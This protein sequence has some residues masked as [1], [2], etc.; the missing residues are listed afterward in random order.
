MKTPPSKLP[1]GEARV[2]EAKAPLRTPSAAASSASA[3]PRYVAWHP[4]PLPQDLALASGLDQS[5]LLAL[6]TQGLPTP[7]S[8]AGSRE[9]LLADPRL[10][11]EEVKGLNLLAWIGGIGLGLAGMAAAAFSL[12]LVPALGPAVLLAGLAMGLAGPALGGWLVARTHKSRSAQTRALRIAAQSKALTPLQERV[13]ALAIQLRGVDLPEIA[14]RDLLSALVDLSA[15][16]SERPDQARIGELE[17]AVLAVEGLL[18]PS[19][20]AGQKSDPQAVL[21]LAQAAHQARGETR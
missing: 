16:L 8:R 12:F 13:R 11:I 10:Q 15:D 18:A 3:L 7:V 4:G 5:T 14:E 19:P 20:S 6:R 9:Q 17:Q 21:R 2:N 1:I